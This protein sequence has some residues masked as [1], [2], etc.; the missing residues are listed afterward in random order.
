MFGFVS[1]LGFWGLRV[2]Q[3]ASG[4]ALGAWASEIGAYGFVEA[5]P[6]R[7]LRKMDPRWR[8]LVALRLVEWV[9]LCSG[10]KYPRFKTLNPKPYTPQVLNLRGLVMAA[11][12]TSS[13]YHWPVH[14]VEGLGWCG[15]IALTAKSKPQTPEPVNLACRLLSWLLL[16]SHWLS[17]GRSWMEGRSYRFR[18]WAV[19]YYS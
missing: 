14:G 19:H 13:G 2:I 6:P 12:Q 8:G 4:F 11:D 5:L 1:G 3:S 10:F 17:K 7:H 18:K 15:N 16:L 9:S